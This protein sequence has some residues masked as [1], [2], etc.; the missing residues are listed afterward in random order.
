M[1]SALPRIL[2]LGGASDARRLA[3]LA[4]AAGFEVTSS[5]AGRTSAP[6]LPVGAS[7]IGGFGGVAGLTAYLQDARIELLVDATHPFA[8]QMS[9]HAAAAATMAG[10]P[11][12][13]LQRPAWTQRPGDRWL[14]VQTILEA[15]AMLPGLAA[16][17]FLTIGRQDLAA[18]ADLDGIWFLYRMIEEPAADTLRPHGQLLLDRGPFTEQGEHDLICKHNLQAIVT[19][20]SGGNDTYPKIAA[21]RALGLPVVMIERPTPPASETVSTP[22][23]AL[24]WLNARRAQMEP[25]R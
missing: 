12:L 18:F 22:A 14:P 8:D 2:I 17:V 23:E 21:A 19:R 7:R 10:V 6:L 1:Q 20:N 25:T 3:A 5:L 13:L 9:E 24:A 11:R 4:V 15:A 16:R